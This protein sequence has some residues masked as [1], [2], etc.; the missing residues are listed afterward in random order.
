MKR[1]TSVTKLA[2]GAFA[3]ISLS[4]GLAAQSGQT[5]ATPAAPPDPRV[6]LKPGLRDAGTAAKNMILVSSLGKPAGFD[7]PTGAAGLT[8]ANSDIAF[9]HETLFLGN[10]YGINMYDIEDPSKVKIKTSMPCQGG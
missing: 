6:G 5:P 7:D 2:V 8:F 9:Q 3:A 1:V 10:F 4:A